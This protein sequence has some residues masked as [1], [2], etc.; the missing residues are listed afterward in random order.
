M[1]L[2]N[3]IFIIVILL[4]QSVMAKNEDVNTLTADQ[5]NKF[6]NVMAQIKHLYYE[7]RDFNALFDNAIKGMM[8][9]LDP[10]SAYIS[11]DQMKDF[12]SASTGLY[13]GLGMEVEP[14]KDGAVKVVSSFDNTPAKRAGLKSGDL[15]L[16]INDT[17]LQH[18]DLTSAVKLM[19]GKPNTTVELTILS[20]GKNKPEKIK[21]TREVIKFAA[22]K[23]KVIDEHI[24]Y[25][26]IS[27]FNEKT[28]HQVVKAIQ[29]V[30]KQ[31][32]NKLHGM[33]I[34]VRDNPG[35]LLDSVA[36]ISDL[37][38]DANK[39]DKKVIVSVKGRAS[40]EI[41]KNATK[42]DTLNGLP[43]VVLINKGSASASEILAGALKD[44][45]RAVIVGT[46]TFGKGSV[47][48]V[49]PIGTDSMIKL[50]TA[51]YYTPND[52]SIQANGIMPDIYINLT[53]LPKPDKEASAFAN[54]SESS[55]M[56]HLKNVKN[57]ADNKQIIQAEKDK[58]NLAHE[59]FQL[60]QAV[61]IVEGL[62]SM[63]A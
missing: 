3:R 57:K 31:S 13:G 34:D 25:I 17:I 5:V 52:I 63:E 41:I 21:L 44:H 38:L 6:A 14:D 61:R 18:M 55:L 43:I 19:K 24:G 46:E 10:H 50:T 15:I 20:E 60:Y 45:N 62:H 26:R 49:I 30:K 59:D 11:P 58:M 27:S 7:D 36:E 40:P 33:V 42:G 16:A 51:L 32:K 37:F 35:G 48:S 8:Q 54:L 9:G 2:F 29:N 23:S 1:S 47:Q 28:F 53:E 22:V 56:K 12:N 39:L 4:L